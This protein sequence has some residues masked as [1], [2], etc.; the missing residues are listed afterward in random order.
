MI[1]QMPKPRGAERGE[2]ATQVSCTDNVNGGH[3]IAGAARRS[4]SPKGGR[5]KFGKATPGVI[6]SAIGVPGVT[7]PQDFCTGYLKGTCT[8]GDDCTFPH[9]EADVVQTIKNARGRYCAK[10]TDQLQALQDAEA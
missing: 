3:G 8:R 5:P 2:R 1:R 9:L 7:Q 6:A 4:P 10:V